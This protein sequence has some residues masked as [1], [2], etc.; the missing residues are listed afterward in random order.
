MSG[1]MVVIDAS[2]M[3]EVLVGG[4]DTTSRLVD[5]ALAAPQLL[6]AEVGHT[7]RR[8]A[9]VT[10]ELTADTA[11]QALLDF[12]A[13]EILRCDHA[14]LVARAWDL[15]HNLSFYDGLYVALAEMLE[16]PLVTIDVRLAGAPGVDVPVEILPLGA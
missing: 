16:V 5:A 10:R 6:D 14:M 11:A 12:G 7:L 2:A 13:T 3:V 1:R 9:V 8:K 4:I 15:R